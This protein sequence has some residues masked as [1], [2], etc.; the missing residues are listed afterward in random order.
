MSPG[1]ARALFASI[2]VCT[3]ATL[4]GCAQPEHAV[5]IEARSQG[6]VETLQV[7]VIDLS[8]ERPPTRTSPRP[9][10]RSAEDIQTGEPVRIAVPLPGPMRALVHVVATGRDATQR[11]VATRCYDAGGVV[12]DTV[13]L[14]GPIGADLDAD[15]DAFPVDPGATCR[16]PGEEGRTTS[17]DFACDASEG[18]DCDDADATIHPGAPELCRD[19][20]D[21]DCDGRDAECEDRDRDDW[22]SCSAADAPGTCDCED[23]VREI[24]PGA[25]EICRDGVDQ[26][27]DG[28]DGICDQDGDGFEA[29]RETGGSPDCDDTDPEIFPGAVEVC[30]PRDDPDAVARD[31]DCNGFV[32]D[33]P[34]CTDD[35]LDRDGSPACTDV[36]PGAG[37]ARTDCDCDDCDAGIHPG[38][39]DFCGNGLDE[40]QNGTDSACPSGDADLDGFASLAAGGADCDDTSASI[41]PGAPERCG[42]GIAQS[43]IADVDCA[44]GDTDAD[45]YVPPADCGPDDAAQAPGQAEVCNTLDDDC[46]GTTNE[47]LGTPVAGLPYG[48]SGCVLGDARLGP[49]CAGT[50]A[51][52]TDFLTSV[53]HC[54]GCRVACNVPGGDV[55]ADVCIGGVCD[56]SSQGGALGACTSGTTCCSGAGCRDLQ[57]DVDN[58]GFCGL[59]CD[60]ASDRCV[61]GSCSCG[62]LGRP[63]DSGATCCG[64]G[65]V[66][67]QT[68]ENNCGVCGNVCGVSSSCVAGRCTCDA[69]FAD[70]DA[71]PATGCE[72][73]TRTDS[74][75]CGACRNVCMR[76][77]ASAV[78]VDSTCQTGSCT[79]ARANCDGVDSNGC[80]V[81]TRSDELHCG[82]CGNECGTNAT[83][84]SGGCACDT[85]FGDCSA[86][87]LGCETDLRTSVSNC[88]G[89]GIACSANQTCSARSCVC[90]PSFGDCNAS[91]GCETDLRTTAAHCGRCGNDCGPNATCAGGACMCAPSFGDCSAVAGCE[92]DL[93]T[94]AAHCGMCG[95]NCGPN[96]SCVGS[97]CVCAPSFGNCTAAAGCE[98]DLRI[99]PTSCGGCGNDCGPNSTC[100]GSACGCAANFGDCTAAAGCETDLRTNDAHCGMCGNACGPG[101][102]CVGSNCSCT[103][104][105]GDCTATAGCETD[106]RTTDA[107]CGMCGNDCGPN[108]GCSGSTCSCDADFDDCTT[109]AGCETDTSSSLAH[110]G[111]CNSPCDAMRADSCVD[112]DCQCG[113][114][115]PCNAGQTCTGGACTMM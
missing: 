42:D 67:T 81:D 71:N 1:R 83:C 46:D 34:D 15:G 97:G 6:D 38:A 74:S 18:A 114:G 106:L 99:T 48:P 93:R 13:L 73:D 94:T 54:G 27:C 62:T 69:G 3:A 56:C 26:D 79:A 17:C 5:L 10:R 12:R 19:D 25:T 4:P 109:A 36:A 32:D 107:H 30:T 40:D 115:P 2:L 76:A 75:H 113:D 80:E 95:N 61:D 103:P 59:A 105:F 112:G 49:T 9:V 44:G 14:V 68:D 102:D 53:F 45:Q 51:C 60:D 101:S 57:T 55:V 37:C 50:G 87:T 24:N 31:E 52:V 43:C 28:R 92:T 110:C 39:I 21:Q 89:C 72:V 108:A 91:A 98:T 77:G 35:D 16:D 82:G 78:C 111:A 20:V 23:G 66:D 41:Y 29:D 86:A 63:C 90:L 47:V 85:N 70:C 100:A 11:F 22:R 96:A 8:G 104:S 84:S 58:C 7:T 33:A 64:A 65:C 88:G